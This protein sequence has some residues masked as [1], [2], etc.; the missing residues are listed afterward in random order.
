MTLSRGSWPRKGGA[1]CSLKLGHGAAGSDGGSHD[2]HPIGGLPMIPYLR[3]DFW[4]CGQ[5]GC[6]V[7]NGCAHSCGTAVAP[8]PAVRFTTRT[9]TAVCVR[10]G[11]PYAYDANYCVRCGKAVR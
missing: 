3:C 11:E 4:M 5:C 8:P 10:C 6:W 2:N 1:A 7:P 9:D